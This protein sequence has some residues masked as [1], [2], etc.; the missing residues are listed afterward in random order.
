MPGQTL[1]EIR[2]LLAEA[3]LAPQHRFG[4]HFLIDLNLMRKVVAAA[5]LQPADTVLEVGPGTGSLTEILLDR[6]AR[7]VAVEIDHGL[8]GILRRRLGLEDIQNQRVDAMLAAQG[9][10]LHQR[11]TRVADQPAA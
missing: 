10:A 9:V 2:R 1:S 5:D 8:Q 4:Q 3:G 6:G 7:V 11:E